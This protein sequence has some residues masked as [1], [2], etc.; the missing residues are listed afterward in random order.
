[1]IKTIGSERCILS[2]DLGQPQNPTPVEGM[3]LF[4]ATMLHHGLTPDEINLMVKKNPA[5]L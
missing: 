2:T 1:M 4:I 3:R 5:G